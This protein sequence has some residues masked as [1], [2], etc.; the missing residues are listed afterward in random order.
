VAAFAFFLRVLCVKAFAV[1]FA[2]VVVF[3]VV[4]FLVVIPAGNLL[5]LL[6]LPLPFFRCHPE[7][8]AKDPRISSC[9]FFLFAQ[10]LEARSS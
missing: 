1:A 4:V 9:L 3:L 5:L 6:H 2:V 10:Y 8:Q 7:P